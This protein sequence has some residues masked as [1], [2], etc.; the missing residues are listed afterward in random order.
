[1]SRGERPGLSRNTII[2]IQPSIQDKPSTFS[3]FIFPRQSPA[4]WGE[5][6]TF[7]DLI[8]GESAR[9]PSRAIKT[10]WA[11]SMSFA[12]QVVFMCSTWVFGTAQGATNQLRIAIYTRFGLGPTRLRCGFGMTLISLPNQ[13]H[14]GLF[15]WTD[16]SHKDPVAD[17]L[18]ALEP[19]FEAD[20]GRLELINR[21]KLWRYITGDP[22]ADVDYWLTRIENEWGLP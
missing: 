11:K 2:K 17:H 15:F 18:M 3:F 10:S 7:R 13:I 14:R 12:R 6:A 4:Q 8:C 19:W 5:H 9:P 1:M 16:P 21:L 20:T 22:K